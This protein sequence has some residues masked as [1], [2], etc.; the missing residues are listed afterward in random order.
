MS[1]NKT[2]C[3]KC[4]GS[5]FFMKQ[6]NNNTGLYCGDCGAWQKWLNKDEIN[7]WKHYFEQLDEM[8]ILKEEKEIDK[9]VQDYINGI[10][11]PTGTNFYDNTSLI[12]C[13][14]R[15][16]EWINNELEREHKETHIS[17]SDFTR[18]LSYC[19]GLSK[20]KVC[21]ENV[22]AGREFDEY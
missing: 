17:N 8:R 15:L 2:R 9:I 18:S 12:E 11:K 6:H 4:N 13:L 22:L 14:N 20:V 10:S 5:A 7:A 19:F 3:R 1:I 21:I 16:V